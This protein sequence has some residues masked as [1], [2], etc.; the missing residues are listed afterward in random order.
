M[1]FL[2]KSISAAGIDLV[3]IQ[4]NVH[5]LRYMQQINQPMSD[6]PT[7]KKHFQQKNIAYTI[8]TKI[9]TLLMQ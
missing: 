2:V 1:L 7:N 5:I 9:E 8:K 6:I 4:L 3:R